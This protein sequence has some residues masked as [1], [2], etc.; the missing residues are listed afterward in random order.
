MAFK[1]PAPTKPGLWRRTPPALFPAIM[2]LFGLGLAWRRA[3]EVAG[4][5]AGIGE[6]ILGAV[7]LLYLFALLAYCGKMFRRP[8]VIVE[9]LRILPGRAGVGAMVLCLYLLSLTFVPYASEVALGLLFAAFT[10]HGALVLL[11]IY[12]FATGPA[13]QRRVTPVWHL[14]FVG[15][16]IGG[17]AANALEFYGTAFIILGVTALIAVAIWAIS[18]DQLVK[19]T[20]PAPL[21]PLLAIHV[22]PAALLGLVA[23]G[24]EFHSV[25]HVFAALA[26]ILV[27]SLAARAVWVVAAGFSPLWGALT[28]PAAAT[29]SLWLA[30]G[31]IWHWPGVGLLALTTLAIPVIA[32]RILRLWAGGQLAV[33]TNAATA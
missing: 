15:F 8:A 30:L 23:Y 2:G 29:A 11:L 21:R 9:E 17:L 28:F 16:I 12:V 24:F 27:A 26:A 32:F 1:P 31:G 4:V 3:T 13:E 5:P 7:T 22:A 19:E 10:V 20:V 25:A 18:A 6:A 14:N 33:K